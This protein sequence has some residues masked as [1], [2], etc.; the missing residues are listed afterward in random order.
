MGRKRKS[1][2]RTRQK[3]R[4]VHAHA[5]RENG[6]FDLGLSLLDEQVPEHQ[7]IIKKL[8]EGIRQRD[9][10]AARLSMLRKVAAAMLAF[11]I[12]GGSVA[13]YVIYE[14]GLAAKRIGSVGKRRRQRGRMRT[15]TAQMTEA[16]RAN[17]EHATPSERAK[18]QRSRKRE[19][20]RDGEA[21]KDV[22][23]TQDSRKPRAGT[24]EGGTCKSRRRS[25]SK[26]RGERSV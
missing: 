9:S 26:G 16:A 24:R 21:A 13:M 18:E 2:S 17:N 10:H 19:K 12:V 22:R 20:A 15:P 25:C 4:L 3:R 1:T 5:A 14:R 11:I 8:R 6:D 23:H 7:P